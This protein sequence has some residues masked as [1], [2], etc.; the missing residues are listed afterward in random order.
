[1]TADQRV[2]LFT[3][4]LVALGRLLKLAPQS[5]AGLAIEKQLTYLIGVASGKLPPDRLHQISIGVLAAREIE[6]FDDDLADR[7]HECSAEVD[8]MIREAALAGVPV[9]PT[10]D[11]P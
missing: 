7:L 4:A 9:V 1:M 8:V 6:G 10:P 5:P 2:R 3:E 11:G